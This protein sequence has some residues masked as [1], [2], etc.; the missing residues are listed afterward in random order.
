[1]VHWGKENKRK[2][3]PRAETLKLRNALKRVRLPYKEVVAFI[4]PHHLGGRMQWL[5][6]VVWVSSKRHM[7]VILFDHKWGAGHSP[8]NRTIAA[9][10]LKKQFLSERG[11]PI[12]ILPRHYATDE[13]ELLLRRWVKTMAGRQVE[14]GQTLT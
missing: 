14:A 9:N 6:F 11:T 1:M 12:L 10:S 2:E 3:F 4:N 13:Y 5:D 8:S 7:G